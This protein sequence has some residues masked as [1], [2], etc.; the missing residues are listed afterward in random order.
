M[1]PTMPIIPEISS[2][3]A[4]LLLT[5]ILGWYFKLD[6]TLCGEILQMLSSIFTLLTYMISLLVVEFLVEQRWFEQFSS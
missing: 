2:F 3:L 5:S 6:K 1:A 4:L